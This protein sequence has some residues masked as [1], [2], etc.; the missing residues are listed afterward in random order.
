MNSIFNYLK[1]KE[2]QLIIVLFFPSIIYYFN[3]ILKI[4]GLNGYMSYAYG[5]LAIY[6]VYIIISALGRQNGSKVLIFLIGCLLLLISAFFVHS[7]GKYII[8]EEY[9]SIYTFLTSDLGNFYNL[10]L[11]IVVLYLSGVELE[12]VFNKSVLVSRLIITLQIITFVLAMRFG[13][14]EDLTEDYMSFAYYGLLPAMVMF[15]NRKEA[16]IN[17]IIMLIALLLLLIIGCRGALVTILTFVFLYFVFK[18]LISGD[19]SLIFLLVLA[20]LIVYFIDFNSILTNLNEN[21]SAIGFSSRTLTKFLEGEDA[22]SSS[23]GRNAITKLAIQNLKLLPDG[24]WG[25]RQYSNVYVHNWILEML[26]DFGLLWG[27]IIILYIAYLNV[28]SSIKVIIL[29]NK[30]FIGMICFSLSMIWVKYVLSS[31]F[32]IDSG[33]ALAIMMLLYISKSKSV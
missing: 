27:S 23:E 12:C 15:V 31:S 18:Q 32:L 16:L 33:F 4:S 14:F 28:K 7:N 19:K 30:N 17:L 25:D 1:S 9:L 26:L 24:L 29:K 3:F 13:A 11:P 8:G 6:N 22:F 10:V 5:I 21:L 2:G 20:G